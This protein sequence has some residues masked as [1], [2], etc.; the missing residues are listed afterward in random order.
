[1]KKLFLTFNLIFFIFLLSNLFSEEIIIANFDN[2][3]W[4]T[5]YGGGEISLTSDN[6]EVPAGNTVISKSFDSTFDHTS[7]SGY[8]VK[9]NYN[10]DSYGGIYFVFTSDATLH[11]YI[12]GYKYK[13]LYF[14]LRSS[15]ETSDWYMQLKDKD[16]NKIELSLGKIG[17]EWNKFEY[18]LEN[19]AQ[20]YNSVNFSNLN[21][22]VLI[23]TN[24]SSS[25]TLYIDDIV[26]DDMGYIDTFYSANHKISLSSYKIDTDNQ[27]IRIRIIPSSLTK[28]KISALNQEGMNIKKFDTGDFY[29]TPKN[30][31]IFIWNGK[32]DNNQYINNGIYFLK[33]NFTDN[34]GK[35][36]T[37]IKPILVVR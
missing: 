5:L 18:N 13:Y 9:L 35:S 27:E 21:I 26:F 36:S 14:Y 31:Y 30:E 7:G 2:G 6:D 28:I 17:T 32:D 15:S 3:A 12:N 33:I 20:I 19:L 16:N 22:L 8:S 10:I 24:N 34:N 11:P 1:M 29:Y 23:N 37:V 4:S 25:G